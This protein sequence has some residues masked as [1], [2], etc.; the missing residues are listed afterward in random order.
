MDELDFSDADLSG[1]N[2]RGGLRRR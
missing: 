1:C 2:F